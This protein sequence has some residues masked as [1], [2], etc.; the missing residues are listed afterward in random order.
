MNHCPISGAQVSRMEP[1][2]REMA[3]TV[4]KMDAA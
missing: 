4:E 3:R 2:R 1:G